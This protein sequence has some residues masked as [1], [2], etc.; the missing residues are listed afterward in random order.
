MRIGISD[1]ATSEARIEEIDLD[2]SQ[3]EFDLARQVLSFPINV[4]CLMGDKLEVMAHYVNTAGN[5]DPIERLI[6][7]GLAALRIDVS[8]LMNII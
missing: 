4:P 7:T 6:F 5:L 8:H 2:R 3:H 1:P